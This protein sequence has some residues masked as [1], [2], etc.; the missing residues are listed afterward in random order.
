M[1]KSLLS[2]LVLVTL[3]FTSCSQAPDLNIKSYNKSETANLNDSANAPFC[4]IA[5]ELDV[6][7][8][9][10]QDTVLNKINTTLIEAVLGSSFINLDYTEAINSYI[11]GYSQEYI[12][13]ITPLY[14]DEIA[15]INDN[16]DMPSAAFMYELANKTRISTISPNYISFKNEFFS[17]AGG[18]HGMYST[19]YMGFDL[20]TGEPLTLKDIFNVDFELKLTEV[21]YEKLVG[22]YFEDSFFDLKEDLKPIENF[23]LTKEGIRFIYPLYQIAPYSL[24]EP[25]V[26]IPYKELD[27]ILNKTNP[28]VKNFI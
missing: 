18:A 5:I 15:S 4:E 3:L 6:I 9:P 25:T 24:G 22:Y 13:S 20:K 14:L 28:I 17:Y 16:N 21:I 8:N 7:E 11:S 1:N 26:I 10:K 19:T 2:R 27:S 23:E 12:N